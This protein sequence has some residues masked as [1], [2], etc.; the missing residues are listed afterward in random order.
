M[1]LDTKRAEAETNRVPIDSHRSRR[2]SAES[3]YEVSLEAPVPPAVVWDHLTDPVKR[4]K[5]QRLVSEVLAQTDGRRGVGT[6]NHCMHGPDVIIEHVADWRPFLYITLRYQADGVKDWAWTY[7]LD[8]IES[9]TRLTV[10]LSDPGAGMWDEIG[11]DFMASV[12][13]QAHHLEAMLLA[14]ANTAVAS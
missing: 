3:V 14:A 4:P 2:A 6:I 13:D 1:G 8:K 10:R 5:W 9:G 12:D 11:T 7:Q